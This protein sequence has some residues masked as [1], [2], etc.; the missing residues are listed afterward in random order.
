MGAADGE[1]KSRWEPRKV[2]V[3]CRIQKKPTQEPKTE[4]ISYMASRL[5]WARFIQKV[6]EVDP[7][8]YE[9]CGH[10]MK[11]IAVITNSQEVRW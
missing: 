2:Q 5:T 1:G 7:L 3:L 10:E 11:V 8:I 9:K 4:T 6:Y